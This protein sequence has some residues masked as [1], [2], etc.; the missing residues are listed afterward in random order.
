MDGCGELLQTSWGHILCSR[1][2]VMVWSQGSCKPP[3]N[4][5]NKRSKAQSSK[6]QTGVLQSMESQIV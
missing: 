3:P 5:P 1:G 4:P 6:A 2:Q